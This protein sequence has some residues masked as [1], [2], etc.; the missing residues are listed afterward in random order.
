MAA[1]YYGLLNIAVEKMEQVKGKYEGDLQFTMYKVQFKSS[2][3]LRLA[4][5]EER[6]GFRRE[7]RVTNSE[8]SI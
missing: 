3:R 8:G 6:K 5:M 4:K 1:L 2:A 7:V